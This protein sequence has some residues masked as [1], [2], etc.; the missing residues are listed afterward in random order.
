MTRHPGSAPGSPRTARPG[1]IG[2]VPPGAVRWV[3]RCTGPFSRAVRTGRWAGSGGAA[4]AARSET[5][6]TVRGAVAARGRRYGPGVSGQVGLGTPGGDQD[7]PHRAGRGPAV[8]GPLHPRGRGRA[9]RLRLLHRRRRR[10]RPPRPR[11]L[12]R[13]RLRAGALAGRNSERVRA[14]ARARRALARRRYR[15]GAPVDPRRRARPPRPQ[16]V[17]RPG[18]RGRPARDRLRHRLRRLQHPA[19]H[20]QRRRRHPGLHVARAGQGL[21]QRHR[22]QRRLLA[23]LHPGLRRHRPRPLPRRQPGRDGLHAAPRGARP[24]RAARGAAAA[25]RVLHADGGAAAPQPRRPPGAARPA[26]LRLR[27]RRQRH[28]LRLA[29]RVRRRPHRGAPRRPRRRLRGEPG[30][31]RRTPAAPAP[32]S[33]TAAARVHPGRAVPRA[34]LAR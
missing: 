12:A 24:R 11:P 19:D 33:G 6:R 2:G 1:T 20:D 29:A 28:R 23:R 3:R 5:D 10:R 26:P 30:A 34:G 25:H 14:A 9:R 17:Q 27:Q 7:G 18:R 4:D 15:R 22:C 8:P 13:H 21:P 32:A 31:P 16:A